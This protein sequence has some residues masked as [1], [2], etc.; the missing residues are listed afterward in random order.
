M[1]RKIPETQK[2]RLI[3]SVVCS[4][5]S[6]KVQVTFLPRGN[7]GDGVE[8]RIRDFTDVGSKLNLNLGIERSRNGTVTLSTSAKQLDDGQQSFYVH[9]LYH[10]QAEDGSVQMAPWGDLRRQFRTTD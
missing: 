10:L 1:L 9:L 8:K 3:D 7:S 4:V 5:N 6:A 2:D